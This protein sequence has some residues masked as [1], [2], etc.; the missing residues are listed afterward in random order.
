MIRLRRTCLAL[1][2]PGESIHGVSCMTDTAFFSAVL[3]LTAPWSIDSVQLDLPAKRVTLRLASAPDTRWQWQGQAAKVHDYHE[4]TWRHLDT[5]QL[6]TVIHAKVPRVKLSDGSTRMLPVPWAHGRG[7]TLAF[8]C[9]AIQVLS[10]GATINEAATLLGLNWRQANGI[11]QRAV[12]RG[13][14]R[15]EIKQVTHLGIDE[16]SFRK[17][18]RYGTLINDIDEGKVLE[19]VE[20]RKAEDGIRALKG[21]GNEIC[22]KVTAVAMDMSGA[23]ISAVTQQCPQA[24]IVFDR[25]HVR[26]LLGDM[27]DQVRRAEHRD[28]LAQ[29]DKRLTGTRYWFLSNPENLTRKQRASFAI[30]QT[31]NLQTAKAWRY[32]ANFEGFWRARTVA[33]AET[34]FKQ[35]YQGAVRCSLEPVKRVAR[36]LKSHLPGLLNYTRHRITNALSESLNSRVQSLKNA[37]RGFHHFASFRVRILFHLGKLDLLPH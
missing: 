35:W 6:E 36:T 2:K 33:E 4:A 30:L 15:R 7:W 1:A 18:H 28:L 31:Q 22:S 11:M 29:G 10:S 13:L 14:L 37:A 12:E 32:Q 8:E 23:Y 9:F 20:G 26:S 34:Y 16:K 24:D 19:V 17:R 5:M 25:W 21:L 3:G 27:I